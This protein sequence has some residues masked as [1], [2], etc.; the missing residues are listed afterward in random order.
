MVRPSILP[1]RRVSRKGLELIARFEGF[2][3][4]PYNDASR[5]PNATVGYGHL[6]HLGPVTDADREL[7]GTISREHA[8][9]LLRLDTATAAAAVCQVKPRIRSQARFDALTSLVFNIGVGN[10]GRSTLLRRLNSGPLRRGAADQ[11]LRWDRAGGRELL[12]L[13]NRR[14]AER[15]LFLTGRY[16]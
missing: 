3:A 8:L 9:E 5:P 7:W 15:A 1:P 13:K 12:G 16:S 2:S 11:F 10:F 6:I 4:K 14:A